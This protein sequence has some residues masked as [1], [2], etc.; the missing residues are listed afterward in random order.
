MIEQGKKHWIKDIKTFNS[1]N[2]KWENVIKVS[3]DQV[4][5]DGE[6]KISLSVNQLISQ[7]SFNSPKPF[8]LVKPTPSLSCS[9]NTSILRVLKWHPRDSVPLG[10][11]QPFSVP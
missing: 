11:R 1:L 4:Y 7:I 5:P 8:H 2:L 3:S 10:M 6:V 9:S